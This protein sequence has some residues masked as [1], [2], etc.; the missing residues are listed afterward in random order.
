MLAVANIA[1]AESVRY[2]LVDLGPPDR[3]RRAGRCN[4]KGWVQ[5]GTFLYR[6]TIGWT[7]LPTYP[8]YDQSIGYD[9]NERGEVALMLQKNGANSPGYWSPT[10]GLVRF[11]VPVGMAYNA[12]KAMN[13]LGE[14]T[15]YGVD[16]DNGFLKVWLHRPDQPTIDLGRCP[17]GPGG[18]PRDIN[19][20]GTIACYHGEPDG[21][22]GGNLI[23]RDGTWVNF[24]HA[25]GYD[26]VPETIDGDGNVSGSTFL[27]GPTYWN[28]N[29]TWGS[30]GRVEG[31]LHGLYPLCANSKGWVV[32]YGGTLLELHAFL[33]RPGLSLIV[34]D[35][36]IDD[37]KTGWTIGGASGIAENGTITGWAHWQGDQPNKWRSILLYPNAGANV[38]SKPLDLSGGL[39]SMQFF[40]P[41]SS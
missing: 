37:S 10:A 13:N 25:A 23:L 20:R 16:P 31:K 38:R 28:S 2:H 21:Q 39:L 30:L 11:E 3:F 22:H 7:V 12:T 6:P 35:D 4:S 24:G 8:G 36:L 33:Y 40:P 18:E 9:I 15:G 5:D 34:L 27:G 17:F 14:I 41:K 26:F 1:K 29:G 32:G 19:D